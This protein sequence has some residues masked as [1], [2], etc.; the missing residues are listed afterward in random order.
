MAH[1]CSTSYFRLTSHLA[2]SICLST[3]DWPRSPLHNTHA[4]SIYTFFHPACA[5]HLELCRAYTPLP[6]LFPYSRGL[7]VR[8][9]PT[10]PGPHPSPLKA[11]CRMFL[12]PSPHRIHFDAHLSRSRRMSS[13]F[14]HW[15]GPSR[16]FVL[17]CPLAKCRVAP[18]CKSGRVPPC[19]PLQAALRVPLCRTPSRR[20]RFVTHRSGTPRIR[21]SVPREAGPRELVHEYECLCR[22]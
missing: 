20:T 4:S 12:W 17:P 11:A 18:L 9:C 22:E 14:P 13:S 6:S 3:H 19:G 2:V 7:C 5:I 15:I 1:Q 8:T 16:W 21:M 10:A